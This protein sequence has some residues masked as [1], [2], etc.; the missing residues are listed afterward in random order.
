MKELEPL[1][2]VTR[3]I[4][5]YLNTTEHRLSGRLLSGSS[6]IRIGLTLRVNLSGIL[7]N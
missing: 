3:N 7:Q 6:I 2:F 5:K 4:Q 1:D